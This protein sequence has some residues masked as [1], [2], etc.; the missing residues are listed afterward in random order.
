MEVMI[1]AFGTY[2]S[3]E[4]GRSSSKRDL[5]SLDGSAILFITFLCLG[6][7]SRLNTMIA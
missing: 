3:S 6:I 1:L 5:S 2:G 7:E 4:M